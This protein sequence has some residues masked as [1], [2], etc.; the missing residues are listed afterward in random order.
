MTL[1]ITAS[2]LLILMSI[3]YLAWIKDDDGI[4]NPL[5]IEIFL[6]ICVVIILFD[7]FL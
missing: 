3:P 2:I 1:N 6:Y 4:D 7:I 5:L